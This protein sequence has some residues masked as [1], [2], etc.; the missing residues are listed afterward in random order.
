[1]FFPVFT[2][3]FTAYVSRKLTLLKYYY[4]YNFTVIRIHTKYSEVIK[5][6][7]NEQIVFI[8]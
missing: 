7:K 8:S 4:Y 2:L 6:R 3:P 1:M 5:F